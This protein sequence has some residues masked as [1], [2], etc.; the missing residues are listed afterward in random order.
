MDNIQQLKQWIED[1]DRI[2]FFGGAGVSTESGIPDFRSVDGLYNQKYD[3]PPET[4]LSH[5]FFMAHPE[6]YYKF[7]RD[8]LVVDGAKP[9]RA[10]LRLAELEREGKLQAV[11][12]QNID[13]LHQ[14]AG[15]RLADAFLRIANRYNRH[16][17]KRRMPVYVA[18]VLDFRICVLKSG[19]MMILEFVLMQW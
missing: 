12:T 14:A 19:I 7:H 9:N 17:A 2:V 13:G 5:S 3:Y 11:I 1:S 6:E 4:I 18:S 16:L 15:N 8:K 10:H